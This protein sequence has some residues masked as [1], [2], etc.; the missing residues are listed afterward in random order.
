MTAVCAFASPAAKPI[1]SAAARAALFSHRCCMDS[2]E[3]RVMVADA[4]NYHPFGRRAKEKC[5]PRKGGVVPGREFRRDLTKAGRTRPPVIALKGS[6]GST[7]LEQL[8]LHARNAE[9]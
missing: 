9:R 2:P 1:A 4:R 5:S 8:W 6:R 3:M 7:V